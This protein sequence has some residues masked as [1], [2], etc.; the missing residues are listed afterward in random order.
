MTPIRIQRQ[1]TK[2][3]KHPPNTLFVTRPL[4]HGNPFKIT[5]SNGGYRVERGNEGAMSS[6]KKKTAQQ[7]AVALFRAYLSI[8]AGEEPDRYAEL[9]EQVRG[10]DYIA[11]SCKLTDM[12][13]ADVWIELAA[14]PGAEPEEG[15]LS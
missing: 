1:R 3:F 2:G 15:L 8:M 11:C 9:I 4:P 7:I 10:A 6:S 12:C 14:R 13:H 5:K